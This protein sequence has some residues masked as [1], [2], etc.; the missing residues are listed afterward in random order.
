MFVIFF[1]PSCDGSHLLS[2]SLLP[3][4]LHC[5][6]SIEQQ[7]AFIQHETAKNV[8]QEWKQQINLQ[9]SYIRNSSICDDSQF[10][11]FQLVKVFADACLYQVDN[12]IHYSPFLNIMIQMENIKRDKCNNDDDHQYDKDYSVWYL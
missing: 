11:V 4:L 12:C 9:I 6:E 3:L 5:I 1:P 2:M 8:I 10:P 7:S